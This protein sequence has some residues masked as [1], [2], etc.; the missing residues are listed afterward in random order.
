MV[1]RSNQNLKH[2]LVEGGQETRDVGGVVG[3]KEESEAT[4]PDGGLAE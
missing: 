2:G 4:S 1:E 3:S